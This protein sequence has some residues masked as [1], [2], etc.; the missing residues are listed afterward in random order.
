MLLGKPDVGALCKHLTRHI[1][2]SGREGDVIFSPRSAEDPFDEMEA[3][4]RHRASWARRLD[5]PHWTR[6][7]GLVLDGEVRG[8][9]DLHGG[10]LVSEFHRVTLGMGIERSARR[11]GHGRAL[12]AAAIAWA[13]KHEVAWID[14]GV[15]SANAPARALYRSAGFVEVATTRDRFRVEGQRIDDIAMTLEL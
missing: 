14:L 12:L 5:E 9:L 15:F 1:A 8:H 2:E 7:W 10:R 3:T 11:Q 13:R 4:K 6:T